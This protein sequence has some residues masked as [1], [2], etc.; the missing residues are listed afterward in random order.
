MAGSLGTLTGPF[1]ILRSVY[2]NGLH[3]DDSRG[4][5]LLVRAAAA[6]TLASYRVDQSPT[7]LALNRSILKRALIRRGRRCMSSWVDD[8]FRAGRSTADAID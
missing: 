1:I 3:W 2:G 5:Q 8:S 7:A 6:L 4:S